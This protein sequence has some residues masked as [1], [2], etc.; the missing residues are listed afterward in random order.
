MPHATRDP[1]SVKTANEPEMTEACSIGYIGVDVLNN[2]TVC[3]EAVGLIA[4]DVPLDL[5][6]VYRFDKPTYYQDETLAGLGDRIH[7]LYPLGWLAAGWALFCAPWIFG[8]RFWTTLGKLITTPT[9]GWRQRVRL[10]WHF[11]PA[12]CLAMYWR[13]KRIGHIHAHW[14]HTATT[15]AMHTAELLGIGFSFTGHANDLFVHRVALAAKLRRARFVVCISEFH[16]Q[17]YLALGADPA[18]LQVV[19]CGIDTQRF[20]P[21]EFME[22]SDDTHCPYI[23]GVGRLVEKKGFHRLIEA[24]AELRD[25]G[26]EYDC[27]IAG[28][29]PEETALRQLAKRLELGD[30]VTIT[31]RAVLQEDLE[32]LLRTATVFALPCVRDRDGDMDGLPQVLIEAMACGIPVVSTVLVGIPDL[33]HDGLNGLLVPPENAVALADAL[34]R[35]IGHPQWARDL[36]VAGMAWARLHFDRNDAIRRLRELFIWSAET[37]GRTSPPYR[38]LSAPEAEFDAKPQTAS[39]ESAIAV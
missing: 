21:A 10:V 31:G 35:M 19:Y 13:K 37:R 29:G 30:R 16:R 7:S 11:V 20:Q 39:T 5:V 18:R 26:L 23:L 22:D 1:S 14:A 34:E 6:S 32:P 8:I 28:S 15:I 33:V 2:A 9:E 17:Y 38:W 3:N 27:V 4:A 12:V 25:R 24:C 36:G